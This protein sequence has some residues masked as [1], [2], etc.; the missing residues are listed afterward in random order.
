MGSAPNLAP[1]RR[2]SASPR[3]TI[4]LF[5][6]S[7]NPSPAATPAAIADTFGKRLDFVVDA[8][9][10]LAEPSTVIDFSEQ[11]PVILRVGKGD[12]TP[13]E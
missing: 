11:E 7:P 5:V 13:F 2:I 9:E 8:G 1:S 6:L 10:R 3:V 12:V 4:R